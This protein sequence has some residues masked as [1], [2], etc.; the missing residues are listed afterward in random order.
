MIIIKG[1]GNM[2]Q[3]NNGIQID[4]KIAYEQ[5]MERL[6]QKERE[7]VELR[8]LYAMAMQ[9]LHELKHKYNEEH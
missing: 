7:V 3:N 8:V 1:E 9:E 6:F 4:A 5:A 2:E